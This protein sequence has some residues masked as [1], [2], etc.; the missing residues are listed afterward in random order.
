MAGNREANGQE[1]KPA[2]RGRGWFGR[3]APRRAAGE[4]PSKAAAAA[5]LGN[6]PQ[7]QSLPGQISGLTPSMGADVPTVGGWGLVFVRQAD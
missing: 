7:H 1:R 3:P 4:W 5:A 2:S 6:A